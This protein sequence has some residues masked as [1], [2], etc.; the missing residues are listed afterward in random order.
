MTSIQFHQLLSS[1]SSL[2]EQTLPLLE[3]ITRT[4]PWFQTAQVLYA[5]NLHKVNNI[6]YPA[7]LKKAAVYAGDRRILYKH[8]FGQ[9]IENVILTSETIVPENVKVIEKPAEIDSQGKNIDPVGKISYGVEQKK[10][11]SILEAEI[12]REAINAVINL[13][14][15]K[16]TEEAEDSFSAGDEKN[17]DPRKEEI[18]ERDSVETPVMAIERDLSS[19]KSFTGW[20][21]AVSSKEP[22][23][24]DIKSRSTKDQKQKEIPTDEFV[25]RFI[26]EQPVVKAGTDFFS[27]ENMARL[28]IIDDESFV[29]ETLAR[30]YAKQGNI[31]KA[32]RI[33]NKLAGQ[34]PDKS[35][36][37]LQCINELPR[38]DK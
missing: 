35:E 15:K 27:P 31:E 12:L 23:G 38:S 8:I 2:T 13:E 17:A 11:I 9:V 10:E 29:T 20:L 21:M 37:Y 26:L 16:E 33:F 18:P 6:H 30:I 1:P 3:E 34:F 19:A 5:V 36:Y 7:Q 28:S 22:V 4:F 32:K 24:R 14:V 25:N